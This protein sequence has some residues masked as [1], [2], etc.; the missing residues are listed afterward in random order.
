MN[1]NG[2]S[3]DFV[4]AGATGFVGRRLTRALLRDGSRVR[5]LVRNASRARSILGEE[6]ELIEIDLDGRPAE[7]AEAMRGALHGY[8]LVHLMSG[9][10]GYAE[11]ERSIARGFGSAASL[12]GV[13]RLSY[14]GGLG[15][16]SPHLSSRRATAEAL[17]RNGPPLTYFRAAMV[18]G[19][20]SESYELLNSIIDRL[21]VAPS[22][23]W[24]DNRTQPIGIRDVVAYLVAS[25]WTPA[26][27][28]REVQIGGPQVLSH[29]E[30][31]EALARERGV[32]PPRWLPLGDRIANPG[33]MAAGAATVTRGNPAVA[34]ELTFGLGEDTVVEDRSGAELFAIRP[35]PMSTVFQRCL[36]EEQRTRA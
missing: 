29:R 15:G 34:A 8:F 5:C 28:G 6:P 4:V 17:A 1:V 10:T 18:V 7:L 33:V 22:P 23:S 16:R 21:P 36:D 3:G 32:S 13:P 30:V 35:E 26:A 20:G 12:A 2:S 9:G 14:L 31:I 19:P 24:L 27:S 25:A 11:R